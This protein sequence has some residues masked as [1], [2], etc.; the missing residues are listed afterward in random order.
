MLRHGS[1]SESALFDYF[2]SFYS[3][4]GPFAAKT[5]SGD[6]KQKKQRNHISDK[7]TFRPQL[8]DHKQKTTTFAIEFFILR[9]KSKI[10]VFT[11]LKNTHVTHTKNKRVSKLYFWLLA[12]KLVIMVMFF[13]VFVHSSP[14]F[15]LL[16][17][18]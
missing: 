13:F 7:F 17:R 12:P 16:F 6:F 3:I 2:P 14:L 10:S 9:T 18:H 1:G 11:A 8:Q 5:D 4:S 15:P